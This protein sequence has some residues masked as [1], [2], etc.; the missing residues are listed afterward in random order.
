MK[1]ERII[2]IIFSF[3]LSVILITICSKNSPI[4]CFNDWVDGNAFY[5]MGK[6]MINGYIPYKDLFEQKG[7]VLYLI[8]GI[9]YLLTKNSF[10]GVYILE[11]IFAS[12]FIY[13]ILKIIELTNI[14]NTKKYL[15]AL[16]TCSI[17][18]SSSFFVQGGSAEE[19]CLPLLIYS[20]Y[21]FL[22]VINEQT[23]NKKIIFINGFIAGIISLI[24]F[25]FLGFWFIWMALIFFKTILARQYK[26][27]IIHCLIFISGMLTSILPWIIYFVANNALKDFI[28]TYI[29]FNF[30]AYTTKL[31]IIDRFKN[32]IINFK[33]Q[34][35]QSKLLFHLITFGFIGCLFT[36]DLFKNIYSKIFV[37]LS[38]LFLG[39]GIYI[40]GLPY[41]YY[42]LLNEVYIVFGIIFLF[43]LINKNIEL[44]NKMKKII[45]IMITIMV[46]LFSGYRVYNNQNFK[47]INL[48]KDNY[49]QFVFDKVIKKSDDKT[50]LNYDNLDGGFYTVSKLIPT[51][52]YF[53]KQNIAH[54]RYPEILNEQN[55]IIRESDVEFVIIRE[56]YG[57]KDYHLT[58]PYLNDNY[59]LLMQHSQIYEGMDF[60]YFLYKRKEKI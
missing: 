42:F 58:I 33:N 12:I 5:T 41:N 26:D 34:F 31:T 27:S 30:Q 57:N 40:G 47:D 44:T 4:Y 13:Y 38:F 10:M 50:I 19:F 18:Y 37:I 39:I 48:K 54:E 23:I 59:D 56:Y 55:R 6:G 46:I 20:L 32:L 16:L 8:Y 9:G 15:A 2:K 21:S 36:N 52:K 7:P 51:T 29:L 49:A 25:N 11:I 17:I 53:M 43:K 22:N 35:F 3:I 24:K 60:E 14:K 1:K 45:S 28:D